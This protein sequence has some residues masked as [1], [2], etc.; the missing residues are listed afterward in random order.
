MKWWCA[1]MIPAA[2]RAAVLAQQRHWHSWSSGRGLFLSRPWGS[3]IACCLSSSGR[4]GGPGWVAEEEAVEEMSRLCSVRV[5]KEEAAKV[6]SF[7]PT[8]MTLW[9]SY[10]VCPFCWLCQ[11]TQAGKNKNGYFLNCP[12]ANCQNLR[13]RILWYK[14][15]CGQIWQ[16][17]SCYLESAYS[18]LFPRRMPA[19]FPHSEVPFS[20]IL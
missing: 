20:F 3:G 14:R 6:S 12:I 11:D 9:S 7:L 15:G 1:R 8:W 4:D 2:A 16:T 13:V 10:R 18:N 5:G 19:F 17:F